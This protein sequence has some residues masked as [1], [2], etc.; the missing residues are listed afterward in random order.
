[1]L[2]YIE[3]YHAFNLLLIYFALY[4]GKFLNYL[5]Y[6]FSGQVTYVCILL[7]IM[8]YRLCKKYSSHLQLIL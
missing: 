4:S 3:K 1:M 6:Q 8:N 2:I 5:T 7:L